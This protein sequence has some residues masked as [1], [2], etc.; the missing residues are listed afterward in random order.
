VIL[1]AAPAGI[2]YTPASNIGRVLRIIQADKAVP[3]Y[4]DTPTAIR[5]VTGG[6]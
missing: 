4:E 6:G 2:V 1:G 3:L 5:A